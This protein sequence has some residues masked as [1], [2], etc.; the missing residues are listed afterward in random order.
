[1]GMMDSLPLGKSSG[2]AFFLGNYLPVTLKP[3]QG[4]RGHPG[5]RQDWIWDKF[6][7]A[8]ATRV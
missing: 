1:M 4:W 3:W 7:P 2:D 6:P 5:G 8:R